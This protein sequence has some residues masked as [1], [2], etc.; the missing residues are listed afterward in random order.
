MNKTLK[1]F[2]VVLLS[3]LTFAC[4]ND[5]EPAVQRQLQLGATESRAANDMQSFD[6]SFLM[7]AVKKNRTGTLP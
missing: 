1:Y 2:C 4:S 5:V 3:T 6:L 7:L